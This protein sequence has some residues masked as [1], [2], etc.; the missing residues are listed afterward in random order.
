MWH[1][2]VLLD[3]SDTP[4]PSV[5]RTKGW[6]SLM[7]KPLRC[8]IIFIQEFYSNIHSID[9][10]VPWFATTFRGT[11]IVVTSDLISEVLHVPRVSHTDYPSFKH[12]WTMFRDKLLSHFCETPSMCGKKQ[13]TPCSSFAKGPRFLNMVMTFTLTPLSHYNSITEPRARF[14]LSLLE[15]LSIDFPTHFITFIIDVY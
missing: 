8:P 4:L 9:T 12:L 13:N 7:E 10:F 11:R 14:L 5:I 3:F 1:H 6:D 15:D 2:V